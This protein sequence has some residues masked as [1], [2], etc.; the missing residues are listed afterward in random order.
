MMALRMRFLAAV[1]ACGSPAELLYC[2]PPITIDMVT[3]NPTRADNKV[4]S[5]LIYFAIK[6]QLLAVQVLLPD[7]AGSVQW[8]TVS[9]AVLHLA[10]FTEQAASLPTTQPLVPLELASFVGAAS[11]RPTGAYAQ[12]PVNMTSNATVF[13]LVLILCSIF[14][15]YTVKISYNQAIFRIFSHL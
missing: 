13:R 5:G 4:I 9:F 1:A 11:A 7:A 14:N 8:A 6:L 12:I 10:E 3:T 15:H 2:M